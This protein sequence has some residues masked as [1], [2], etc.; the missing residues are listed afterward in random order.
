MF[1]EAE[2]ILD[3]FDLGE[4]DEAALK[5]I[6]DLTSD[7]KIDKKESDKLTCNS[8]HS[9]LLTMSSAPYGH[10]NDDRTRLKII[11]SFNELSFG[12]RLSLSQQL[13]RLLIEE[14]EMA[15]SLVSA[16]AETDSTISSLTLAQD[17]SFDIDGL[18][19]MSVTVRETEWG[20]DTSSTLLEGFLSKLRY[21]DALRHIMLDTCQDKK[22]EANGQELLLNSL[23]QNVDSLTLL[24]ISDDLLDTY[25]SLSAD[26]ISLID[27]RGFA[28]K[29]LALKNRFEL[30]GDISNANL[31]NAK[32]L[33]ASINSQIVDFRDNL[34]NLRFDLE[35]RNIKAYTQSNELSLDG[36]VSNQ[37]QSKISVQD[38]E[39]WIL[40]S[41]KVRSD[42]LN[43]LA[44]P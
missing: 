27:E 17:S 25:P 2:H 38:A 24:E 5:P 21:F 40:M 3:S 32:S 37:F 41:Q 14:F 16:I 26:I 20:C 6:L 18:A 30:V 36:N 43:S 15:P 42:V 13:S 11:K 31:S 8:F 39:N 7:Q 34:P 44:L 29:A 22:N 28:H 12:L 19:A 35:D 4:T 10:T 9:L 23:K 33:S 1:A